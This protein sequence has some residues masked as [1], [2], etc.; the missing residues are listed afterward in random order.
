VRRTRAALAILTG[1]IVLALAV[2]YVRRTSPGPLSAVHARVPELRGFSSCSACHGGLFGK[3]TD[4]CLSCHR[5]VS[6][7]VAESRGLHGSLGRGRAE[8]C[9]RCHS[10]HHGADF[11]MVNRAS[12][13]RAGV[14]DPARFDHASIGF[15][16]AGRHLE[17]GCADC[18][19]NATV[20]V[21]PPGGRRFL[22]LE[23]RC[24]SC[25]E[26]PHAGAMPADCAS[27]HGQTV[28]D[29][30]A[31]EGHEKRLPLTGGHGDASC[32]A[33]H[34]K[35]TL[36][37][38]EALGR[39]DA[40][41][42]RSCADC[43]ASPHRESF[44]AATPDCGACHLPDHVSFAPEGLAVTPAQHAA[45]GFPLDRPHA[46]VACAACHDRG[47]AS[48]AERHPGRG[49]DDCAACH[50]DPHRGQFRKTLCIECHARDDFR[51]HRFDE[52]RHA[53]T[54]LPLTGSHLA[55]TCGDCH[56]RALSDDPV[57]FRGTPPRCD[58]CH[59]DV[60]G[61]RIERK[62]GD[63][64]RCH[65]TTAFAEV[66]EGRFDHGAE[67]GFPVRGAHAQATCEACH[68]RRPRPDAKGRSFGLVSERFAP[69][70]GCATCHADPHEGRFEERCERCHEETSFRTPG[71]GF[72]HGRDA[73]FPLEDA[74]AAADCSACHAR[75]RKPDAKGRTWRRAQGR[76]CAS[77]HADP[78]AG[79]FDE[80]CESCHESAASFA[81]LD[82]DHDRDSRFPLDATHGALG[83]ADCHKVSGPPGRRIVRYRP[84]GVDCADCHGLQNDPLHRRKR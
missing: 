77:C 83:C 49:A 32:R 50:E 67:T 45:T 8:R 42:A 27:C 24:A 25:H 66:P 52:T 55:A 41:P 65:A 29:R 37:A 22:G 84:L 1:G 48:F 51:P 74:H 30:L 68:P 78:H 4:A 61:G 46:E 80:S 3:M 71:A 56:K 7:Q 2:G 59:A 12:F 15:A 73:G 35:G 40:P 21:L 76:A 33:C 38:L 43:H 81:R 34:A 54:R 57:R 6:A 72:Q 39:P 70:R 16:M 19:E 5:D 14:P 36:H 60:H 58:A 23:K 20:E 26:D 13:Q 17:I 62:K 53:A 63:C 75:L 79:Q 31:S 82:F 69:Y 28:W 11:A 44:L 9:A 47:E 10:D 64:G 18:H